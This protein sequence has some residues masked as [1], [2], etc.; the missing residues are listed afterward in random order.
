MSVSVNDNESKHDYYG[1]SNKHKYNRQADYPVL[2]PE[3]STKSVV[4]YSILVLA[5]IF[6][7]SASAISGYHAWNE[8][9]GDPTWIRMI[10]L[11]IAII[12]SPI[13]LF[14]IF[15]KITVFK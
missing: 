2:K 15:V 14:Y 1:F 12:F 8:F 11:Y 7:I 5:I 6:Y 4:M 13:Y 3:I 9:P 10:R